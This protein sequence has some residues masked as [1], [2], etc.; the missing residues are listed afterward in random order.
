MSAVPETYKVIR[1]NAG[2]IENED[3]PTF[4]YKVEANLRPPELMS[5]T[6]VCLHGGSEEIIARAMTLDAA[7]E[8]LATNKLRNHPRLRWITIHGPEGLVEK[9]EKTQR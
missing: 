4:P 6:F 9:F 3:D 2:R 5:F 8:F 1:H 7:N